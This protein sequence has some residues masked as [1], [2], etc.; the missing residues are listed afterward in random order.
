MKWK[1]EPAEPTEERHTMRAHGVTISIQDA[2][3]DPTSR[4][5]GLVMSL[6]AHTKRRA[7]ECLET[8]PREAIAKARAALD[9]FENSLEN[10]S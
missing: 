1:H 9:S 7:S 8:W 5:Q 3:G 4:W 6:G 10:E 2:S